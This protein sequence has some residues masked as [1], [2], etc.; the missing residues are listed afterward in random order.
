MKKK[1]MK[2]IKLW[3]MI[4]F[5]QNSHNVLKSFLC[6][7]YRI[8]HQPEVKQHIWIYV[9]WIFPYI[10]SKS[11]VKLFDV[12]QLVLLSVGKIFHPYEQRKTLSGQLSKVIPWKFQLFIKLKIP[13]FQSVIVV[14]IF[15]ETNTGIT[16]FCLS[17]HES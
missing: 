5:S 10:P 8:K 1:K 14:E 17:T 4:F 13:F 3:K 9:G 11:T 12:F 7:K 2:K 6:M 15:H 16:S